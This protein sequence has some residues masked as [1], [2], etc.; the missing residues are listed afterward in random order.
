MTP[1]DLMRYL[2]GELSPEE[3]RRVEVAVETSTELSR[4]LALY[5]AMKED[6]QGL[7][8][9]PTRPGDTWSRVNRRLTRPV[10]WAL[11][12]VGTAV[13]ALYGGYVYT[14]TPGVLVEKL[15]TGAVVIGV[16]LLLAS[17]IWEQYQAWL[18]DPYRD[19]HR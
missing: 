18:A 15:A 16:L 4:E 9:S 7:S 11:L 2:D 5:R 3:R 1:E 12:I 13:W 17:V 14:T 8:F 10:G 19:V 6:F